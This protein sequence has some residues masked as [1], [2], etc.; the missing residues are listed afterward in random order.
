M[1][2]IFSNSSMQYMARD[3]WHRICFSRTRWWVHQLAEGRL[4]ILNTQLWQ[5]FNPSPCRTSLCK[6]ARRWRTC[7][8]HNIMMKNASILSTIRRLNWVSHRELTTQSHC[9]SMSYPRI[10][11]WWGR[12]K[13]GK[14][15]RPI[16]LAW[17]V[18]VRYLLTPITKYASYARSPAVIRASLSG[19]QIVMRHYMRSLACVRMQILSKLSSG[20]L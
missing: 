10:S 3:V 13:F 1:I 16:L 4:V 2:Q 19:L 15:T 11:G 7:C 14:N 20:L 6:V 17:P 5:A 12:Q 9:S 8:P 18:K